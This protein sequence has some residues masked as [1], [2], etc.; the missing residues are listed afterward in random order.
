MIR[1]AICAIAFSIGLT[2]AAQADELRFHG[3]LAQDGVRERVTELLGEQPA[4][5]DFVLERGGVEG[6]PITLT[7]KDQSYEYY[8]TCR[9]H[10]CAMK[11]I[12]MMIGEDGVVYVRLFGT[13]TDDQVFGEPPAEIEK[14]L[15][16]QG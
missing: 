5:V 15:R 10:E 9:P 11:R 6:K 1:H 8:E 16:A 12:G 14:V 2:A 4:W 13:K 7:L 3:A